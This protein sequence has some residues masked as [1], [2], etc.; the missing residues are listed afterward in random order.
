MACGIGEKRQ[1]C[2]WIVFTLAQDA[3]VENRF[4][5]VASDHR[6]APKVNIAGGLSSVMRTTPFEDLMYTPAATQYIFAKVEDGCLQKRVQATTKMLHQ[7]FRAI[8]VGNM[9]VEE[10]YAKMVPMFPPRVFRTLEYQKVGLPEKRVPHTKEREKYLATADEDGR[11]G[12]APPQE[13]VHFL[14]EEPKGVKRRGRPPKTTPAKFRLPSTPHSS[15]SAP[16][17]SSLQGGGSAS[18]GEK[19]SEEKE[20][21]VL[22]SCD[23]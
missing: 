8:K 3:D 22:S 18:A 7:E 19:L 10:A 17:A 16:A 21:Q 14:A 1:W 15:A 23:L 20:I 4:Y 12:D 13:S 5:F 6:L 11:A 2:G 9:T